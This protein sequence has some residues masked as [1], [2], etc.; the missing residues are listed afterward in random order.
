MPASLGVQ[1]K[2]KRRLALLCAIPLVFSLIVFLVAQQ[3]Q[4]TALDVVTHQDV[5]S[6]MSS[7][8]SLTQDAEMSLRGFL[9]S[10]D[11]RDLAPYQRALAELKSRTELGRNLMRDV[12]DLQ[13]EADRV[14]Q[15]VDKRFAEVAQVLQT[16][17]QLGFSP[18]LDLLR[19]GPSRK[20]LDELRRA[21]AQVQSSLG[22]TQALRDRQARISYLA[23]F[24]FLV[25]LAVTIIVLTGLYH[26]LVNFIQAR[27]TAQQELVA[28]N[29]EL[30]RRIEERT[31]ELQMSNEELQQFAYVASHDL[32]EPLRTMTSF[33][34]LLAARYR[35]RFD[36]DADEFIS[37][38]V[39]SA[40]RMTELID[41]LLALV[42]LRKV[43]QSIHP[44]SFEAMLNDAQMSL[45]MLIREN[46]A[47][48]E[49]GPLPSLAVDTAQITQ[50][51]QNLIAN[52]IKYRHA[53]VC[54]I[55]KITAERR[56][57]E[58]VISV[59]DNG[60]GF[61]QQYADRIFGLFQRLHGRE[62][63]G[64]GIG[65]SI[66]RKIVER[67]GGRIWANSNPG[68][69]AVFSFTLPV[70]L[71]VTRILDSGADSLA[72]SAKTGQ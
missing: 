7:L 32:Q 49:H 1:L 11:E 26:S 23:F 41:G 55:V 37:Y 45:Q 56:S 8:F 39:H 22:N 59:A 33:T 53:D 30:E 31:R 70:S 67:H 35:G 46:D 47:R 40:R 64:S 29:A 5:A 43:G 66:S 21:I 48:I 4:S 28:L 60:Q 71:E 17:R 68:Q 9:L 19:E 57:G 38:I 27:E 18:A 12:P 13:P 63:Q 61:D 16:Q 65:L 25:G 2:T 42:R 69:G 44:T 20:S 54:P 3:S 36:A 52:S 10:G 15:L 72:M 24:F 14:F 51:L 58:W 62:I 6:A 50:L 34:Q